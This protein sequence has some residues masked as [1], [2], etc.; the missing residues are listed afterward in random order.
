[1]PLSSAFGRRQH[2]LTFLASPK[3]GHGPPP[4]TDNST[5]SPTGLRSPGAGGVGGDGTAWQGL[6]ASVTRWSIWAQRPEWNRLRGELIGRGLADAGVD[7]CAGSIG[8]R[9]GPPQPTS[10]QWSSSWTMVLELWVDEVLFATGRDTAN[11][12]IGLET[13]DSTPRPAGRR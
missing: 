3:P 1:M 5:R 11:D 13:Q 9:A 7:A 4:L 6:G 10:R 12:D 2:S 8:T